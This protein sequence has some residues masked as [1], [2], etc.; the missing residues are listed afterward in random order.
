MDIDRE[1]DYLIGHKERHLTQNN[2]VIPEYLIPCYSRMA[3]IANL[4]ASK[5]ATMKVIAALLRVCVLDE[6][7]DV[8]REA[9]LGLVK[10]NP[11]IAK[12]ALVAGTYDTDYQV[13]S[14][15]IEELHRLEPTAAIETAKRLKNDEDEMVR[16][17]ALGLLGLP[18]TQQA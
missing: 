14:T 4:V 5:N 18:H 3:A 16:D 13:R 15:A 6:E 8:R 2:N 17:Y 12:V 10:I 7:E 11:E 9:L 1:I